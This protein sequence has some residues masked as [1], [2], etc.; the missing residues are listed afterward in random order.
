MGKER[1]PVPGVARS[2]FRREQA[3]HTVRADRAAFGYTL[4]IE[5][6]STGSVLGVIVDSAIYRDGR[7]V[8]ERQD[9]S[10]MAAS[11]DAD[12]GIA[13][14]GL[15]R[16]SRAEFEEVARES[17]CTSS[18]S[19]TRSTHTSALLERYGKTPLVLRPAR[20]VDDT[21]TVEFMRSTLQGRVQITV[22]H[23]EAPDPVTSVAAGGP[24]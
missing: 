14:I 6:G 7:R 19:M 21:E 4:R 16:P 2:R 1:R 24:S 15:Y 22:R 5:S 17:R 8:S 20:Y 3:A 13:W 12:G 18:P 9:V 11:C 23:S 10:E